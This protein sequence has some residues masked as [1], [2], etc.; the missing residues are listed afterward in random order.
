MQTLAKILTGIL[1]VLFVGLGLFFMFNPAGTVEILQ[2][3]PESAGGWAAIRSTFGGLFIGLALLLLRGVMYEEWLPIRIAGIIL[4]V[5]I[6]GRVVS[7]IADGFE[8]S[9]LGPIVVEIV[10]VAICLFA[11]GQ[12]KNAEA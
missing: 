6:I 4:A 9:L 10:L 11:S 2:L 3:T 1:I 5:T 12:F 8:T 7:L